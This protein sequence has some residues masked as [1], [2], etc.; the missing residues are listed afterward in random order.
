MIETGLDVF[1]TGGVFEASPILANAFAAY[2][3]A[4]APAVQVK[5]P[6]F[7]P[8]I[9]GLLLALEAAGTAPTA[10]IVETIRTTFPQ[11]AASKHQARE[12]SGD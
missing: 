11:A 1:P 2:I 8:I 9:G 12:Q 10:A 4:Q 3:A 6:A 7:P 5:K